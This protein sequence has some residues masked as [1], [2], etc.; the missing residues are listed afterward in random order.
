MLFHA[1][2]LGIHRREYGKTYYFNNLRLVRH[3]LKVHLKCTGSANRYCGYRRS[4]SQ[5]S[6][7][8]HPAAMRSSPAMMRLMSQTEIR[9]R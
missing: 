8:S 7:R 2:N 5:P 3:N 9:R 4:S 6:T 1:G